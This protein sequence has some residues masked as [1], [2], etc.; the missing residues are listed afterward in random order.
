MKRNRKFILFFTMLISLSQISLKPDPNEWK[1]KVATEYQL[2][3]SENDDAYIPEYDRMIKSGIVRIEKF[4]EIKYNKPFSVYVHQ[5]RSSLDST[6]QKEWAMPAFKSE[7]WMVAS[8]IGS[9]LDL[10]SPRTWDSQS[11]EHKYSEKKKVEDLITHELTHVY[12]G[13]LNKSSDFSD[14][15]GVDW[16]VEGLATYV[17]GQC[18]SV[19][20]ADVKTS[21]AKGVTPL[22]LDGFWT[23]ELKYG[24]SGTTVMF[25][26]KKYGRKKL[27]ELL[28]YNKKTEI[29]VALEITEAKFIEEWKMFLK[30]I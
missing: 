25:I 27:I 20:I 17:S 29:L 22:T 15:E 16:F 3:Y 18:D 14:V 2:F 9:K 1:T 5:N 7:C 24:L 4:F 10:L 21:I 19:R 6:W 8:G 23:G 28:K 13:Q 12:H 30:S 11:C 26:D